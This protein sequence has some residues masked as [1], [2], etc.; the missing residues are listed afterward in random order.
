M[1]CK[2]YVV[3]Q[4]LLFPKSNN[5]SV[6]HDMA[7]LRAYSLKYEEKNTFHLNNTAFFR[8]MS[9]DQLYN[10]KHSPCVSSMESNVL[11]PSCLHNTHHI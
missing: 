11:F 2:Y 3:H 7:P 8:N 5:I 10:P 6:F 4:N 1:S 9:S